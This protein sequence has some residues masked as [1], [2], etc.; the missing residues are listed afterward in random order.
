G[1]GDG[2][3]RRRCAW[4]RAPAEGTRRGGRTQAGRRRG[5]TSTGDLPGPRSRARAD[6]RGGD[7]RDIGVPIAFRPSARADAVE[8]PARPRGRGDSSEQEVRHLAGHSRWKNIKHKKAAS[9]AKRGKLW[10]KCAKAIM[11][12]ARSG[13][14]DPAMNLGLRYAIDE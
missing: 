5:G 12:A 10:S 13:G 2:A 9:D 11:V 6:G 8:P 3:G 14:G 4:P 7:A 1:A